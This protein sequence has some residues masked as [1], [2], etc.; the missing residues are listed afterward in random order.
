MYDENITPLSII[1][2]WFSEPAT[3]YWFKS[4]AAFDT[5]I[6]NKFENIWELAAAHKLEK[7]KQTAEGCLALIII[8]DQFPLNMYRGLAKSF[9]TE[10][11]AI[12]VCLHA[13]E[14]KFDSQLTHIQLPFLYMPLMH[15]EN[16]EHQSLSVKLFEKAGLDKNLRFAIHHRDL[17]LKFGRFPHRNKILNRPSTKQEM[18]YLASPRAFKG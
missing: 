9:S 14:N 17:I 12:Q 2:F 7:W 3:Q 6:R 10:S 5:E 4:T 1:N 18:E 16:I 8:L 15:S 13:I 11:K